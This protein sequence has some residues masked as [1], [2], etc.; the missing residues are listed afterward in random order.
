[1][2]YTT[3][4]A[5]RLTLT[6]DGDPTDPSTAAGLD[7]ATLTGPCQQASDEVDA[8][9]STRYTVPFDPV[10]TVVGSIATDIAAYLVTLTFRKGQ[11]VE[12]TDPVYLRYQRSLLFL[13]DITTGV[14]ALPAQIAGPP[15]GEVVSANPV[16]SNLFAPE[17]FDLYPA[18]GGR[19][20]AD[21]YGYDGWYG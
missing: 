17:D 7:D 13:K 11:P 3:P 15:Q 14:A 19:L 20:T 16:A 4:S 1:M 10:P 8:R 21:R 2:A 6:A 12:T 9:L 5:V 18:V